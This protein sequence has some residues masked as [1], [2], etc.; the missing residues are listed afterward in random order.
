MKTSILVVDDETAFLDSVVRML[1][2][3]GYEDVTPISNP[4]EVAALLDGLDEETYRTAEAPSPMGPMPLWYA[5][6]TMSM[7]WLGGYRMQLFLYCK[8]AGAEISTPNC[9][10]GI[11][12]PQDEA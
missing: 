1:R 10:E 3:E 7:R 9:W 11:D 8:A 5:L 12:W 2:L 6:F 4:T